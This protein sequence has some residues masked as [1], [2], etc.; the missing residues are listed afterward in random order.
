MALH[1]PPSIHEVLL[2]DFK[3]LNNS[4]YFFI[5]PSLLLDNIDVVLSIAKCTNDAW[6]EEVE[7]LN[8]MLP[9][10][11]RIKGLAILETQ[12]RSKW[13]NDPK[14]KVL[15]DGL[16]FYLLTY[17]NRTNQFIGNVT[18]KVQ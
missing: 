11:L 18:S 2:N 10:G 5:G 7:V 14:K 16:P 1:I 13:N 17:D 8:N 15:E 4:T 9:I 6:E 3:S 12:L